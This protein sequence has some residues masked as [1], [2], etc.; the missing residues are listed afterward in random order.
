VGDVSF[1]GWTH[2]V[3]G[4]GMTQVYVKGHPHMSWPA[5]LSG[6]FAWRLSSHTVAYCYHLMYIFIL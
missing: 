4:E 2:V 6:T 5:E 1:P 3:T